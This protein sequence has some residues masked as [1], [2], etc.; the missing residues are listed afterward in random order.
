MLALITAKPGA[1]DDLGKAVEQSD[2]EETVDQF[3]NVKF[4]EFLSLMKESVF[5]HAISH[6]EMAMCVH[7]V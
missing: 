2:S 4:K 6:A 1:G 5:H 3:G 7:A